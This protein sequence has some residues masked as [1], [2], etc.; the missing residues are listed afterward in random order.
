[1]A[2]VVERWNAHAGIRQ[3]L[4]GFADILGVHPVRREFLLVQTTT[5][6][7]VS[8]RLSKAQGRAEL[9]AWVRA[10]GMFQVHGWHRAGTKWTVKVVAVDAPD[11]AAVV[12]TPRPR[13]GRRARQKELWE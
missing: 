13:R 12:V 4:W 5:L 2:A 11:L 10:G 8:S 7:N 9:A 6:A 3:D 1:V